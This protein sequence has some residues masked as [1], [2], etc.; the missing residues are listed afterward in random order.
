M[1]SCSDATT[2]GTADVRSAETPVAIKADSRRFS[3]RR[4]AVILLFAAPLAAAVV[5]LSP[6]QSGRTG[7]EAF[8]AGQRKDRG[9]KGRGKRSS[10]TRAAFD[11]GELTI[12]RERVMS[13]GPPKD[14]IPALSSPKAIAPSSAVYLEPDD[15][16]V[17]FAANGES[18]AYPIKIL[19]YH[20]VI[21]DVVGGVDVAITYC[22]LCDSALAFDR[23]TSSGVREFGVSG[24]LF[25]SNV[26]M[27]DRTDMTESLWSQLSARGVSGPGAKERMPSLP[28]EL[29]T[30]SDWQ[31]RHPSTKVVSPYTGYRRDYSRS[32]YGAYL[33]SLG[34]MFPVEPVSDRLPAKQPVL[35]VWTE[36]AARA[37][38][39]SAFSEDRLIV[40]DNL[41][42]QSVKLVFSPEANALR[43]VE[44]GESVSWA[45]S[46][47][48]AWYAFHPETDLFE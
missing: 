35:G 12:P 6:D 29:T 21:N 20:E 15:R 11:L 39:L 17:G 7:A 27:Y 4:V 16:V 18:R 43:I 44:A 13:G 38:P 9:R 34:L 45:Y 22:P 31:A 37:Y 32:P 8:L 26:L 5:C 10:T 28:L 40:E 23:R 19:N 2:P 46:L 30:W 42:G 33:D 24:L 41:G 3:W 1:S 25:N 36:D 47:W 14:G 48:F